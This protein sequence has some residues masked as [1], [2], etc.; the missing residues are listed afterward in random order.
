MKKQVVWFLLATRLQSQGR[1]GAD[2][3]EKE[4]NG[5]LHD[6]GE[7]LGPPV[8]ELSWILALQLCVLTVFTPG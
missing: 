2:T 1:D 3:E 6:S 4:K 7:S 8:L 5:D